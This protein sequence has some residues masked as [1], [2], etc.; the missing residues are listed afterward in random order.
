MHKEIRLSGF[1]GQGIGLAGVLIGKAAAL[2][3]GLEGVMTQAYGPEARGGAS[4]AN[5]IISDEQ[6]DYPF[7]QQPDI[8]VAMSQEAY[9][10]F[11]PTARADALVLIDADLV[12]PSAGDG[13]RAIPATRLAEG[14]GR[15]IVANVIM[16]G[17]FTRQ[18][19]VVSRD[20][21]EQALKETLRPK[22]V[23]LNL[24]AFAAGYDYE[25]VTAAS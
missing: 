5:L 24:K 1:G 20:A 10:K 4:S 7:V 6:I 22:L 3:D 23:P 16:V 15:R 9:T 14:L 18:T 19:G 13:V 2:Y 21:M 12:T 11:R 25:W 8:L 17:F